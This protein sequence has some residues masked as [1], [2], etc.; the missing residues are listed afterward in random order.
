MSAT[1]EKTAEVPSL[2]ERIAARANEDSGFRAR[3]LVD[4]VGVIE[5]EFSV[6]LPSS[7]EVRVHEDSLECVHVVLSPSSEL[8]REE[9]AAIAGGGGTAWG[10]W[11]RNDME[12]HRRSSS[13]WR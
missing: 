13:S 1:D 10:R 3:L 9:L 12:A 8:E 4:P 11:G 7:L 6:D 2:E 5:S